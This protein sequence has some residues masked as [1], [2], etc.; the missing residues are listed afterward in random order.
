MQL[1]K[2]SMVL[3][4]FLN[5]VPWDSLKYGVNYGT[6]TGCTYEIMML[7]YHDA[8][9]VSDGD[10]MRLKFVYHDIYMVVLWY[11]L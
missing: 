5:I 9:I 3:R 10:T 2:Y 11:L 1:T 4:C 8:V 6:E 7:Q